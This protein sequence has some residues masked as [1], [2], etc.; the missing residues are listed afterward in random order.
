MSTRRFLARRT[1]AL[2]CAAFS[3]LGC[4]RVVEVLGPGAPGG[5]ASAA[6]ASLTDSSPPDSGTNA[7]R[8][9][10]DAG[11]AHSCAVI[12][13][14]LY[15]WGANDS[16]Q[17]GLADQNARLVATQVGVD[18]DWAE[19]VAAD[20]HSCARR[21]DGSVWCFGANDRGQLGVS[22][23]ATATPT[24]VAL[25]A[26]A[27]AL[28]SEY[29]FTCAI[30]GGRLYCW[31][32]NDEGQLAQNDSYPGVD[33]FAPVPV[34]TFAD[35]SAV[36]VGQGHACGIRAPGTLWCWGRNT[37][38]ELAQ[39]A[40]AAEQIRSPVQVGSDSDFVSV[41]A[42]QSGTCAIRRGGALF[43]AGANTEG[44]LGTG[45]T[46]PRD[47]LTAIG[48][49][50]EQ[51]VSIDQFHACA[52]DGAGSLSCWGRNIEGQLGVGDLTDR[53]TPALVAGGPFQGVSVGRFFTCAVD[54]SGAISCT[55][56]NDAGGLGVGDAIR[57]SSFTPIV[58]PS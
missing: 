52:I 58:P 7:P 29:E 15:C 53:S 10:V 8:V 4:S 28:S 14:A 21:L 39:G 18:R 42:G 46:N 16:G 2:L 38:G 36:S 56:A 41:A 43:C 24:H 32:E 25:P 48:V 26:P 12:D 22:G 6:D 30:L 45:D 40:G 9:Q 33:Q 34:G 23:G 50:S 37:D 49:G 3:L 5:D 35:W 55:G 54:T 17:L 57:R 31:G 11:R 19:V 27:T 13:G 47:T 44:S 51:S 1:H 20:S